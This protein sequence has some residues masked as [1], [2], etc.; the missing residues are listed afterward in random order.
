MSENGR[1][2]QS[3][4]VL[5]LPCFDPRQLD[6]AISATMNLLDEGIDQYQGAG[7][8][9]SATVPRR[10]DEANANHGSCAVVDVA[11]PH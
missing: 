4:L 7:W 11:Q 10:A 5:C 9:N 8:I 2:R 3:F 1:D 6:Y